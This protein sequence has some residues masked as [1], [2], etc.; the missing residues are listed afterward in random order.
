MTFH[1]DL[2]LW[3]YDLNNTVYCIHGS[4]MT[5]ILGV[6]GCH[7]ELYYMTSTRATDYYMNTASPL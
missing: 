7:V 6:I 1:I 2:S 3:M 4:F 5:L